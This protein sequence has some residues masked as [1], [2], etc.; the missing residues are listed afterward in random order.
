MHLRLFSFENLLL[1]YPSDAVRIPLVGG[2]W[3]GS[4]CNDSVNQKYEHIPFMCV[5]R[6]LDEREKNF[7]EMV[8]L[9]KRQMVK[10]ISYQLD[11]NGLQRQDSI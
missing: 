10:I 8:D 3:L 4:F 9:N 5:S 1:E 7:R 6:W 2:G 11:K